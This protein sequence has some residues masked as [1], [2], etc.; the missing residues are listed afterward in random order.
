MPRIEIYPKGKDLRG[1]SLKNALSEDLGI[2]CKMVSVADVYTIEGVDENQAKAIAEELLTE[3]LVQEHF[4]GNKGFKGCWIIEIA[5]RRG[6]Q[7]PVELSAM[8]A[9]A[10][11]GIDAGSVKTSQKVIVEGIGEPDAG[12]IGKFLSNEIIQDCTVGYETSATKTAPL[13]GHS[14]EPRVE[15][16]DLADADETE[17]MR[18]SREGLLSLNIEEMKTIRDYFREIKR[19]PTDGELETI[20]QTWS[21]HCKHKT[22]NSEV[23]YLEDGKRQL[24]RNLFKETIVAATESLN[25][26]WL[27]S[28]FSDNAGIIRFT[29]NVNVA[30]KVETHNHPS[31]LDPYGGAGT[32]IGG[33]IRDI[34]AA[35]L[36]AKPIFNTDVFCFAPPN[37]KGKIPEKILH[38]KRIM[39]GVVNAVRDYGNRMG[40]P[41]VNGAIIFHDN[42]LGAPLVY[43]GTAGIIPDGMEKKRI[44][45][46]E[47]LVVIGGRTGRDGIHGAT[48]SS[49]ELDE[50]SPSSAVQIGNAIE[51]KK[52]MD[53]MLE[54]RDKG[55]YTFVSDCGGGGFSSA[56]GEMAKDTGVRVFLDRV[57]LKHQA[58]VPWEIWVS[59]SQE[60]MVFSVPTGNVD[61][62]IRICRKEGTE[63]TII[64]E[65]TGN[66][67]LEVYYGT[68]RVIDLDME[69]LHQGLPKRSRKAV[70][71]TPMLKEPDFREEKDY[72]P[73]LK[74]ILSH[75][76]IASKEWVIRQYD[77]EVQAATILKPLVGAFNDG[78][79]DAAVIKP[80]FDSWRGIVVSNGINPRYSLIDPY[81]MAAS[82]IDEALRNAVAA[83]GNP[84]HTAI[85]DN[86]CW[87]GVSSE[88]SMGRLTRA[89][90]ACREFAV[91]LELP[92]ISGKDSLNNA[93][94]IERKTIT[95]PDTLLISAVSVT[96]DIRKTV[97]MDA[98]KAGNSIYIV[99]ATYDELGGSYFY[100]LKNE[101]GANVPRVRDSAPIVFEK[102]SSAISKGLVRSCH[103]CSEGGIA[104]AAA[105]MAF[106]GDLGMK[107]SLAAVPYE[108]D[109]KNYKLLFSESNTRFIAEVEKGREKEFESAMKPAPTARVGELS[110]DRLFSVKGLDGEIA[111]S[112]RI[113]E[114]KDSWQQ[115]FRW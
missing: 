52:F 28:V 1:E 11:I 103:D 30:F 113:S 94:N 67:R 21:E 31:A 62:F 90:K 70:W 86:F 79:S 93:F 15:T 101:T 43:C 33:V 25:K 83:G 77:H 64:G 76:S 59:E 73:A 41:T 75:P 36:G 111:I 105:E 78:P 40:I 19:N 18:I 17:L 110:D 74:S 60:R 88:E 37:Y 85:L 45:E 12:R 100:G 50:D 3:R 55:L 5:Y 6:V 68:K 24:I 63:A 27:V 106:S 91:M 61:E 29:D 97:S 104:V 46:G 107:L 8:E 47:L 72:T 49:A 84:A 42:Y 48:F 13:S 2:S 7:D 92:Y 39:K 89:A 14:V 9:I 108:G 80:L 98:K 26:D 10:G 115:T 58:M 102:M 22:F 112:A 81:W 66:K 65:F 56:I 109:K 16:I 82:A 96:D 69:F 51:E 44:S 53:A 4:I 114:L 54:A 71:K 34:L 87:G 38:P 35:G 20:A 23:E 95:I 99:G 32:G 57:P